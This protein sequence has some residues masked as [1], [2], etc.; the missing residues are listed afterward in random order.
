[1]FYFVW[2]KHEAFCSIRHYPWDHIMSGQQVVEVLVESHLDP[3]YKLNI[4]T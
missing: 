3:F 2:L 4:G 1:M